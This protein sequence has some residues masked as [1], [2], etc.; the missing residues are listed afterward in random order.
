MI[1]SLRFDRRSV[2]RVARL[3]P[4]RIVERPTR[5]N[6]HETGTAAGF[7]AHGRDAPRL[8]EVSRRGSGAE[9]AAPRAAERRQVRVR[10]S[11]MRL[12][13]WRDDRAVPP[14]LTS[15]IRD[16]NRPNAILE[17]RNERRRWSSRRWRPA[18]AAWPWPRS[19]SRPAPAPA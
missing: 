5:W 7:R 3:R 12:D 17:R 1:T 18:S 11:E 9:A 2:L 4:S 13:V 8:P 16:P 15:K 14:L 19:R 10:L 6:A